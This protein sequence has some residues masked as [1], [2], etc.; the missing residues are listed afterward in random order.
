M[1]MI[2]KNGN[3]VFAGEIIRA[4]IAVK[5]GK[6]CAI[7]TDI[8]YEGA[9]VTDAEGRLV[10]PGAIDVHTHLA[11][12]YS[13]TISADDYFTG[14]RAALCGGTTTVFDFAGQESGER[15]ADCLKRRNA[16][17]EKDACTDYSFHLG[18]TDISKGILE[19]MEE[20]VSLGVTSFKAYM[21]YDFSL[22]DGE[23]M[24]LLE[25]SKECGCL[26]AVHAENKY[27]IGE[28]I[29]ECLSCGKTDPWY[30]Y[31]SR[32]E[33]TEEEAVVRA[34][35]IAEAAG[36]P[37]Y[38]VHLS[39][40][41]S[42]ESVTAAR[43]KGQA[44]FAET[45]P[46]YLN[47]TNEVYKRADGC[48]FVCSPSIKGQDS[49]NA[50]WAGIKR[51]DI[52]TVATDHCPVQSFEKQWGSKDFTKTPNGC[53]GIENMYPYMLSQANRGVISFCKAVELCSS[54]PAE[55]FGCDNVKGSLA[56]G[57]DADIVIYDL[58]KD[59]TVKNENMHGNSD[60]TI[61]EDTKLKGY[62]TEV[63]S[64]GRL[65][66]KDGTFLGERGYGKF[67]KCSRLN[68]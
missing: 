3:L 1:D 29:K 35:K 50:V 31:M 19:G 58:Y 17:A 62:P 20:C 8:E 54:N 21:T 2:I 56:P 39:S 34:I 60:H 61:W 66:F 42:M 30:H 16:M 67:V 32:P 27:I 5:N 13:G 65:V 63:Y 53:A 45:C 18:V 57:H 24:R 9:S 44:V 41:G 49:Q 25:K 43:A 26:V 4:D 37:L 23:L 51:G 14:T 7:G 12:P 6:I 36:A 46:H 33:F 28:R 10:L 59:V 68:F 40:K 52:Q 11:M 48:N 22:N 55:I 38:I 47:F 64:R 15:F